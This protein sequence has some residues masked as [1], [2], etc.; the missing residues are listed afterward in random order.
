M[1]KAYAAALIC[2]SSANSPS[3]N[4]NYSIFY[5]SSMNSSS[6]SFLANQLCVAYLI[7][8]YPPLYIK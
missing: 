2:I 8:C 1:V 7:S 6:W 3:F 4:S 5:L